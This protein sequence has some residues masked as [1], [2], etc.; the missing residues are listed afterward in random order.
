MSL[1]FEP[2]KNAIYIILGE[3]QAL[4]SSKKNN[5]RWSTTHTYEVKLNNN[6]KFSFHYF[7]CFFLK[8]S[9]ELNSFQKLKNI[10]NSI[11]GKNL[12]KWQRGFQWFVFSR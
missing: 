7:M 5:T 8:E 11:C 9:P 4:T 10:L 12:S 2:P 3:I 1:S 6:N